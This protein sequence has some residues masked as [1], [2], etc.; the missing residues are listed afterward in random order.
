MPFLTPA[1]VLGEE[2]LSRR[3]AKRP[4][5]RR[6]Q[7]THKQNK[8]C[9]ADSSSEKT[10]NPLQ[11][12]GPMKAHAIHLAKV[13]DT[14]QGRPLQKIPTQNNKNSPSVKSITDQKI[15]PRK[16]QANKVDRT[17]LDYVNTRLPTIN[18]C[19]HKYHFESKKNKKLR[20]RRYEND[21]S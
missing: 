16:H 2:V 5:I 4:A 21:L 11:N 17:K 12:F 1:E 9:F 18:V 8:L 10:G 15:S 19:S 20:K 7:K 13:A 14:K 6:T 3:P